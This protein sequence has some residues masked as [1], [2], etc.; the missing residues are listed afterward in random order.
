M[1]GRLFRAATQSSCFV[2][3]SR[4]KTPFKTQGYVNKMPTAD[5]FNPVMARKIV[6]I[7]LPGRTLKSQRGLYHGLVVRRG[8][9]ISYAD[10]KIPRPYK[11]NVH[12]K[13]FFSSILGKKFRVNVS[14]KAYKTMRKYGGFDNYI[15]LTKPK[16]MYSIFGEYLRRVMLH[17]LNH[18][19]LDLKHLHVYGSGKEVAR[20]NRFKRA[21]GI[22]HPTVYRHVDLHKHQLGSPDTW[23]REQVAAINSAQRSLDDGAEA[24]GGARGEDEEE[25][26]FLPEH[27]VSKLDRKL[28]EKRKSDLCAKIYRI[29]VMES[30]KEGLYFE[31]KGGKEIDL[32][33]K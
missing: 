33:Q 26:Q 4:F 32:D 31:D 22:W 9:R 27:S 23:T 14:M 2:L 3:S 7:K 11:I 19:S 25:V 15:L 6:S 5:L 17:K 16:N 24:G 1:L 21:D 29:H 10:N 13:V 8:H 30:A 12:K 18:P 20:P 28:Y